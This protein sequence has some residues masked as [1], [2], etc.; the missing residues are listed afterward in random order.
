M[1]HSENNKNSTNNVNSIAQANEPFH[2]RDN[3][4]DEIDLRELF[5]VIWKSKFVILITTALFAV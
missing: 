5:N 3:A 4:E 2:S 1:E